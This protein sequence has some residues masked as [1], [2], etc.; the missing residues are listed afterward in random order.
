[1]ECQLLQRYILYIYISYF[2]C[3]KYFLA[4]FFQ[5]KETL[6]FQFLHLFYFP[7]AFTKIPVCH[8]YLSPGKQIKFATNTQM[9]AP[10]KT[11]DND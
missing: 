8:P 6:L 11:S 2:K 5:Q 4:Y 10:D 7:S 9:F 3:F 1:M